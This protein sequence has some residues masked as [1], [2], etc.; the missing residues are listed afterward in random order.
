MKKIKTITAS[1][2]M[3]FA[4]L[5][6][7]DV[8][9]AANGKADPVQGYSSDTATIY[10][11]KVLTVSQDNKFPSVNDFEFSM[12]AVK[13]WDNANVSTSQNG[14]VIDVSEM[15]MPEG[16]TT[17]HQKVTAAGT[18][19]VVIQ[20]GNFVSEAN[21]DA[22]DTATEKYRSTPVNIR[23]AKAGYYMYKDR[24]TG[25]LPAS[26]P[27]MAY[28]TNSYYIV[29]YVCNKTDFMINYF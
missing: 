8:N 5:L 6:P 1:I 14:S 24:E 22:A 4:M 19:K 16:V 18:G 3:I 17:E 21:T 12:E 26:A 11:G 28:D 13:A 23:F 7:A 29:V 9:A 25:S 2:L 27:R 10:I 15:P 20:T